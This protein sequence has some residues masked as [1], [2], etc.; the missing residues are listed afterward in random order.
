VYDLFA[1]GGPTSMPGLAL[2]ELRGT[3]YWSG[4]AAYLL[5]IAD[6]SPVFGHALYLG[7]TLT[8]AD[9]SGRVDGARAEPVY[10][11]ALV[12]GGRTPLGPVNVS[13][14]LTSE[15]SWQFVFGLGRPIEERTITDPAW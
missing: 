10:S 8:A 9:M 5:K 13:L 15:S 6:I 3:S 2:G 12:L 1:L 14:A 11:G 4:Q 7:A